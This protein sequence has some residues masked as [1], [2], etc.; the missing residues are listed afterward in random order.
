MVGLNNLFKILQLDDAFIVLKVMY[1]LLL[2]FIFS[3]HNS[4][5]SKKKFFQQ[6][7]LT[8]FLQIPFFLN[9]YCVLE[10]IKGYKL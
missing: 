10:T 3:F 8:V 1:F 2:I 5:F 9:Y 6:L 7:L 4:L